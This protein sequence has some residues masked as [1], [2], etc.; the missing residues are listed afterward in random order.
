M[1]SN[2]CVKIVFTAADPAT[3][4][5]VEASQKAMFAADR[6]N[7]QITVAKLQKRQVTKRPGARQS[8]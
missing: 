6:I 4:R 3:L 5:A 7:G 1:N 2:D 8:R